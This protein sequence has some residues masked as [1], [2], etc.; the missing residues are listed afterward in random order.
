MRRILLFGANGQV[1]RELRV[2]LALLGEL[3]VVARHGTHINADFAAPES[4]AAAVQAVQPDWIVN[5][6]AYTAVDRAES[7]PEL[8]LTINGTAVGAL[9]EAA[10]ACGAL[11]VH[12]STDYVFDG[13]GETPRREDDPVAPLNAYGRTKRAGEEAILAA[14][15]AHLIFRTAWVY[16]LHGANFMRTMRRLARER[17]EL[18]VVADQIGAPTWSRDIANATA[19]VL[20]QLGDDRARWQRDSGLYNLTS[21]GQGSWFEFAEAIIDH[22]RS[23]ETLPVR[24]VL[25]I[26]SAEYPV[27]ARRPA[28]SVLDGS[29]LATRFGVRLPDWRDVWRSVERELE[30]CIDLI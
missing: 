10:K 6:S 4:V 1:A 11:L 18:N 29:K 23:R 22:Q 8:A 7:E 28:F 3:V 30:T 19:L 13:Q 21:A 12:Y 5:A 15:G 17:I 2:S 9:A 16:G 26:S 20:A 14:E 24:A 25:P 27:P